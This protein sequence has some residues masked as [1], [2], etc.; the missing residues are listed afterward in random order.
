MQEEQ[1]FIH[2]HLHTRGSLADAMLKEDDL[3]KAI[4][5]KGMN[6][7]AITDHGNMFN[8]IN[9]Y[10]ACKREGIKPIIGLEAYVAPRSNTLKQHGTD[11]A[12]Y[13]LVLLAENNVGYQ[14]LI[15]IA[16]DASVNGFYY[17]PRTDKTKLSQWHE[18]IIALSA[19]LGGE[20]QSY[21]LKK[22]YDRARETALIYD[23]IFGRG[24]FFLELQD[25][26]LE[27]QGPV[28]EQLIKIHNE[29][30][31]PLVCTNDCHYLTHDDYEAHD[32][33]MAIQAK[34]TVDSDKRKKYGSD[35]FYVK[36]PEEMWKLFGYIPEAL[37]NTV[38]IAN[39]CNV[40]IDFGTNKLPPFY[41]PVNFKGTNLEYL[42][43]LV[44]EGLKKLYPEI[45]Q[46]IK[47]RTEY[48]IS[49]VDGM[50]YVNYFLIV[51]DFFRFCIEGTDKPGQQS[52]KGWRPILTGPGRGSGAGSIL[53]YALG[54]TK[55][56]PIKYD[57]MFERF[58]DPSRISMP[59]VDSDFE[60]SRRQEV[61]DYVIRK[62]GRKS[63][64]QI[65][66]Y[67]TLAARAVI[68][69]VGRALD[70]P[71]SVQD[72]FAKMIPI[73]PGITIESALKQNPDLFQEYDTNEDSHHFLKI[74]MRL[75]GL[76]TYTS[77]HAAGVL[78]TDEKGVTA[79]VPVWANDG[80]IVSQY[81][82]NNLEELGL[83]KMDFLGLKT[84][85][86]IRDA[87]DMIYKN[88]DVTVDLD[89]LYKC[90]DMEPLQLLED[91]RTDGI[92]QLE[93]GGLT[94]FVKELKPKNMNEWIAAIALYRPGPMKFIP[95]YL[96]NRRNPNLIEYSFPE[97]IPILKETYGILTYQEQCMK[98][99]IAIAGYDKSDS[100]GFRRVIS[101]KKKK[102]IPLHRQWF[103]DGRKKIDIDE[104]EKQHDYGHSIPGGIALG[105]NAT[106]LRDFFDKM[107]DFGKYAFNKSHAAAY[108]VVGYATAWLKYYY[109]V[110]FMAALMNSVQNKQDKISRYINHCRN[111]LGIDVI[112]PD[113]NIS[114][115]RFIATKDGQ[116]TFSL[117]VKNMS[118]TGL[119]SIMEQRAIE[120]FSSF[121]EFIL[122]NFDNIGKQDIN[123]LACVGAFHS[124]GVTSSQIVAGAADIA[125]RISKTK[126]ARKRAEISNRAFDV[127]GWLNLYNYIPAG[128]KEF[129]NKV[130]LALEKEYLGLY[131]TGNPIYDYLYYSEQYSNFKLSSMDYEIDEDT[132]AIIMSTPLPSRKSVRF[133]GMFSDIKLTF[134]RKAKAKMAITE[135]EDLTGRAKMMIW[136]D[137]YAVYED[138]LFDDKVYDFSG[139][140]KVDS[141]EPPIIVMESLT[142]LE[143]PKIKKLV[144]KENDKSRLMKIVGDIRYNRLWR[145][146]CP[147]YIK[148]GH[149]RMLLDHT[150]WVNLDRINLTGINYEIIEQ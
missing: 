72:K 140:I 79:H 65:I 118:V 147:V 143:I 19:C 58:L 59:D 52:P 101:K 91:G 145:G 136:P 130:K 14:N 11:D 116:I 133:V 54:I 49:V 113:I 22:E 125:D 100:D 26:G 36:T 48:E 110:E 105:H 115:D 44:Y 55:I 102:L 34:T 33:L 80:A 142:I 68:R 57:L 88:H 78:I 149:I 7:V 90:A 32:I 106:V 77:T 82:K 24:N 30:G 138:M 146:D 13:H 94:E 50:G 119:R 9:F 86:V 63:V 10:K 126:Q 28:N 53:L 81:D 56:D 99:V 60:D 47:E 75:E 129:P 74:C 8:V 107:E 127:Q 150:C 122:R 40:Q 16:S 120:P 29:T 83:L 108:A 98:T 131:L 121:E 46:E 45:T 112:P 37:E 23:N 67:G 117:N 132:G 71:Y 92:F 12:N 43:M 3:A 39:R 15:S 41:P 104:Y 17:R 84:L 144:I 128:L 148:S 31:I 18:G 1:K 76:P 111:V 51:W 2:L 4:K 93:G 95:Q 85:G 70:L 35:Q 137:T 134:T 73:E 61:I 5:E 69:A 114:T 6:A 123:A 89:E 96:A 66:T 139:Y 64:C 62:Y 27:E 97:L 21:L 109:P 103:I 87:M 135:V 25:H 124:I 38:K 141:E 20:V 42:R